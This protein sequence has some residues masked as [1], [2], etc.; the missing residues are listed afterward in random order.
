MSRILLSATLLILLTRVPLG[1]SEASA[2]AQTPAATCISI[3]LP[4][5]QGV[6][7]N[8]PDVATG[9]RDLMVS[10]LTG[11]S[12]KV[13]TLDARLPSQAAIEAKEKGCEP[14]L[15][16]NLT[17]KAAGHGL[18]KA[19]GQAAGY[20]SWYL[21][22]GGT[23]ASATARAVSV[24]GL[25]TVSSLASSTKAKDEVHLQYRLQSSGG[26]VQF[27]PKTETQKASTDGEDLLTP[28]VTRAAEA[29]VTRK[30][31]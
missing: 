22:G 27:G 4:A 17:R 3:V 13:V 16:M 6:P 30:T 14:M 5:V 25:Q 8:G 9:L 2:L 18:T 26:Q 31:P 10:Y 23:V 20:S 7:G 29:I 1:L 21:P 11:P 12:V 19:L 24:V 28:V 15:V